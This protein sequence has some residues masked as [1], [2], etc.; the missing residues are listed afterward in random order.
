MPVNGYLIN[1]NMTKN[2][3]LCYIIQSDSVIFGSLTNDFSWRRFDVFV[4]A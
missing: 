1:A 4:K 3:D 2:V